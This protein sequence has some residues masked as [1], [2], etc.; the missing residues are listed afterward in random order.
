MTTTTTTTTPIDRDTLRDLALAYGV[1]AETI[2]THAWGGV[3]CGYSTTGGGGLVVSVTVRPHRFGGE[4]HEV[5]I[6]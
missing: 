5:R 1:R 6:T 4:V 3:V 2:T